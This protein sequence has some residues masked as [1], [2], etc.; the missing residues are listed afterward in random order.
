[1]TDGESKFDPKI[2]VALEQLEAEPLV[3]LCSP[4]EHCEQCD[5]ARGSI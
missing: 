3:F 1:M 2:A 4:E 5:A